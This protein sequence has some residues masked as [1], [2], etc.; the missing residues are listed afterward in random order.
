MIVDGVMCLGNILF[1]PPPLWSQHDHYG[2]TAW[3]P[4]NYWN[5][6]SSWFLAVE[7]K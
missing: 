3:Y 6:Y 4:D 7:T 2:Q 5:D 1:N